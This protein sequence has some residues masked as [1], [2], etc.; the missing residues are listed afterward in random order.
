MV[1]LE[2]K[3]GDLIEFLN[4]EIK[5]GWDLDVETYRVEIRK[6]IPHKLIFIAFCRIGGKYIAGAYSSLHFANTARNF[7]PLPTDKNI[8][9]L[10]EDCR[11]LNF[12]IQERLF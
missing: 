5:Q 7:I 9:V 2:E 11:H 4:N 6:R 10:K 8:R 3:I 12:C 1:S